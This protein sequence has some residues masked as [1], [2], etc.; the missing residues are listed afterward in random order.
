MIYNTT[1]LPRLFIDVNDD[2][3]VSVRFVWKC[4]V[5]GFAPHPCATKQTATG[6]NK[7]VK[8]ILGVVV[9]AKYRIARCVFCTE[10]VE[11]GRMIARANDAWMHVDC[12]IQVLHPSPPTPE[13]YIKII[14]TV[15]N[16]PV[17]VDT[18]TKIFSQSG[19]ILISAKPGVGKT[20]IFVMLSKIVGPLNVMM[21]VF[22]RLNA[23][24]AQTKGILMANTYHS[25]CISALV[26]MLR[27]AN[28]LVVTGDGHDAG[29]AIL[30]SEAIS[31]A[32][33]QQIHPSETSTKHS[34]MHDMYLDLVSKAVNLAMQSGFGVDENICPGAKQIDDITAWAQ[35][36]DSFYLTEELMEKWDDME[37][38]DCKSEELVSL[39]TKWWE[40]RETEEPFEVNTAIVQYAIELSRRVFHGIYSIFWEGKFEGADNIMYFITDSADFRCGM[41]EKVHLEIM[42]TTFTLAV[43]LVVSALR[44]CLPSELQRSS[45]T[46]NLLI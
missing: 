18:L 1:T 23:D 26:R 25:L 39:L 3:S 33:I 14:P 13:E 5:C 36:L 43:Y 15:T 21:A 45:R 7:E 6:I 44:I 10:S 34:V 20:T 22:S 2:L 11:Q 38:G 46:C 12:A 19:H 4:D 29:L 35:L 42:T 30:S 16:D 31:S 40:T 28:R 32:L 41:A 37:L 17:F 27:A 24:D 8:C 9:P